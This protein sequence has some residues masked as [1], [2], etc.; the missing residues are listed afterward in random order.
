MPKSRYL[1]Q[2]ELTLIFILSLGILLGPAYNSYL[3][4]DYT[5]NSDARDYMQVA[6]GNFDV[7]VTHRYRV[8]VPILAASVASPFEKVYVKLWPHRAATDWPLRL[9]FFITNT[10]LMSFAFVAIWSMMRSMGLGVISS[11]FGFLAVITSRWASLLAGIPYVDSLHLLCMAL[12]A[13][14]IVG[15]VRAPIALSLLL[16]PIAKESFLMMVPLLVWYWPQGNSPK[17]LAGRLP[18][19]FWA[20][21]GIGCMLSLRALIDST[22]A[23]PPRVDG[24]ENAL[25][26]TENILYAIQRVVSPRGLGEIFTVM[27]IFTSVPLTMIATRRRRVFFANN[28]PFAF[29]LLI[30]I[31]LAQVLLSGEAARMLFGFAPLWALAVALTI[32]TTTGK[33]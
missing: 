18:G 12:G 7:T 28:W 2:F 8:V 22:A 23:A 15:G 21:A 25:N 13:W 24:L 20:V 27:G 4:Y 11:S 1:S 3:Y 5:S 33:E 19:I 14:G 17:T 31:C 6:Q 9:G 30:P 29:T 26:H 16:G 32:A 10:L